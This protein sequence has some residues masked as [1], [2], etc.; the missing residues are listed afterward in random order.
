LYGLV[1]SGRG[2]DMVPVI[3]N[4]FKLKHATV[5]NGAGLARL[6]HGE[7]LHM[8]TLLKQP[9]TNRRASVA[10]G[11]G[12]GSEA[13]TLLTGKPKMARNIIL[14][15]E[16][17]QKAKGVAL[18]N[19]VIPP[20]RVAASC[21]FCV[22]LGITTFKQWVENDTD[23]PDNITV[24]YQHNPWKC[25]GAVKLLKKICHECPDAGIDEAACLR[26]IDNPTDVARADGRVAA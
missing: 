9:I 10:G 26:A 7:A 22:E 25:Y 13:L 6:L 12:G 4:D 14:I 2:V 21:P 18:N 24:A 11:G 20:V 19:G 8:T 16:A 23:R 17:Y 5:T 3:A 15:F 1:T